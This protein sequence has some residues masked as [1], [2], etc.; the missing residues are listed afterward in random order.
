M[1]SGLLDAQVRGSTIE[2]VRFS[3]PALEYFDLDKRQGIDEHVPGP[4]VDWLEKDLAQHRSARYRFVISQ[5]PVFSG[6]KTRLGRER[7]ARLL[8][9][10]KVAGYFCG[11]WHRYQRNKH[12]GTWQ[13]VTGGAGGRMDKKPDPGD[14]S[15]Y[16]LLT[17][18]AN[19]GRPQVTVYDLDDRIRDS[20]SL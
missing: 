15:H 12:G 7:I 19:G 14:F 18:P 13:V 2:G 8:E 6:K 9:A 4:V 17:I 16:T 20:F 3:L 10:G 5:E 1:P 11:H